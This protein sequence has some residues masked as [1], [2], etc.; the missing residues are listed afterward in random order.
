[1][2]GVFAKEPRPGQV[3]S[4]LAA[5][6]G[7]EAA[8]RLYDGFVRDWLPRLVPV[9]ALRILAFTPTNARNYF[10]DVSG[11][12]FELEKQSNGDFGARMA[13]FFRRCFDRRAK[14]VVLVGSDS[15][16]LPLSRIDDAFAALGRDDIVFG[17]AE[18]GGYYLIGMS[19]MVLPVFLDVDWSGPDVLSQTI[20][21]IEGGSVAYS[22]LEPWY[23]VDRVT[24]L[25]RLARAI[26]EARNAG[27]DPGLP[28][29]E[30][31]LRTLPGYF[32]S[33]T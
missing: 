9:R 3:K 28:H 11:N 18:D 1:M 17:P 12:R 7:A 21:R 32:E 2:L 22:L 6:I 26:D 29:T 16:D 27:R 23:D 33:R 13:R 10:A 5:A 24:D 4:R 14:R 31:V 19:R 25:H 20:R 30:A 15:P 8:A